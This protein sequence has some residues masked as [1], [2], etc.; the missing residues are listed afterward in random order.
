MVLISSGPCSFLRRQCDEKIHFNICFSLSFSSCN[1]S[2]SLEAV[3]VNAAKTLDIASL[4]TQTRFVA[5][6]IRRIPNWADG[7]WYE[8]NS[9]YTVDGQIVIDVADRIKKQVSMSEFKTAIKKILHYKE[10]RFNSSHEEIYY[11]D[12]YQD[13]GRIYLLLR[14]IFNVSEKI[15]WSK[16]KCFGGWLRPR[17]KEEQEHKSYNAAWPI[18]KHPD[19]TIR[20][21]H[22]R[23]YC[24]PS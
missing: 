13:S 5:T 7:D 18:E 17:S 10:I 23:G 1:S 3:P 15:E 4:D 11:N 2:P 19:G 12:V 16:A 14:V 22:C 9:D 8:H 24:G 20:I 21:H 6:Q